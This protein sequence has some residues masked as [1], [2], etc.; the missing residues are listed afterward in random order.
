MKKLNIIFAILT[1]TVFTVSCETNFDDYDTPRETI[2][3]FS[4]GSATVT[5]PN[6][7]ESSR[8]L[9]IFISDVAST[10]RTFNVVVDPSETNL[11][12]ESYDFESTVTIPANERFGVIVITGYDISLPEEDGIVTLQLESSA[13]YISGRPTVVTIK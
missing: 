7:G 6:G 13:E 3:G 8:D 2:I 10:D 12:N 9:D 1:L 5:V 4:R 11:P